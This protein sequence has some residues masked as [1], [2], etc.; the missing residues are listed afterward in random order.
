MFLCCLGLFER[1][2]CHLE[3]IGSWVLANV[4]APHRRH[5][6]VR[7]PL[8]RG[9]S[10]VWMDEQTANTSALCCSSRGQ[11]SE[12]M[13]NQ[14]SVQLGI[15]LLTLMTTGLLR[16]PF[17][18]AGD[19]EGIQPCPLPAGRGPDGSDDRTPDEEAGR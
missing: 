4:G 19:W 8:H 2:L 10:A 5:R 16:D 3:G 6:V 11:Q 18:H 14:G 13:S 7:R 1:E 17:C 9:G 15:D 12:E